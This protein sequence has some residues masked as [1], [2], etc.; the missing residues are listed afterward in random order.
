MELKSIFERPAI[1]QRVDLVADRVNY[2]NKVV[3]HIA[4]AYTILTASI[5]TVAASVF[6]AVKRL[7]QIATKFV[8][9][10]I[11]LDFKGLLASLIHTV[12]E[13][14][15]SVI[16]AVAFVLIGVA[17]LFV[18]QKVAKFLQ[19]KVAAAREA[20]P[21]MPTFTKEDGVKL[22]KE[23]DE[24]L[25]AFEAAVK[26][27]AELK[28]DA[29][30]EERKAS[31]EKVEAAAKAYV[32]AKNKLNVAYVAA[33]V[34]REALEAKQA[35]R[36]PT[37]EVVQEFFEQPATLD[38]IRQPAE[39]R[40][41]L[42]DLR[43][44]FL[45]EKTAIVGKPKQGDDEAVEGRLDAAKKV[46]KE[47]QDRFAKVG[48]EPK[49]EDKEELEAAKKEAEAAVKKAEKRVAALETELADLEVKIATFEVF[50]PEEKKPEG[51]AKAEKK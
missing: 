29:K 51:E 4:G 50:K 48:V 49:I 2:K 35:N 36:L 21:S 42:Q 20:N 45:E 14:A 23:L 26:A 46:L 12:K 10:L 22:A 27:Q 41:A 31:Q 39:E 40:T 5:V 24:A 17:G 32:E 25:K 8:G 6:T 43:A 38:N 44:R 28:S 1:Q 11:Q 18:P 16:R 7:F 47:A 13:F 37:D 15:L 34:C 9:H 19:E 33:Q 30:D 3:A